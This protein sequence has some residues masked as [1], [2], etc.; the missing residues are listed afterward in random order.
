MIILLRVHNEDGRAI[1]AE[2][3]DHDEYPPPLPPHLRCRCIPS[4]VWRTRELDLRQQFKQCKITS[5]PIYL[6]N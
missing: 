5:T 2:A 4:P 1:H 3:Y 6:S